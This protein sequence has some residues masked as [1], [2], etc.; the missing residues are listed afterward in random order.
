MAELQHDM[1]SQVSL[2]VDAAVKSFKTLTSAVKA[3]TTEWQANAAEAKRNGESQKA[4]QIK[5]DGLSKSVELQKAKL[6]D[7]KKQQSEVDTSTE[8]GTKRYYDLTSQITKTNSQITK[9]SEQLDKAKSG[10][11]YYTTGLADLQKGYKEATQL[12]QSYIAR[13]D[14]EG[15]TDEANK[16]KL[17]SYRN[18][19]EHFTKQL[20][21]QQTEL[22]KVATASGKD[23]DAYR[24]Q[25]IRVNKT[26]T[27]LANAKKQLNDFSSSL[28]RPKPM[29]FFDK[30]KAQLHG[31]A[32]AAKKTK[33]SISDIVKGSAVGAGLVSAVGGLGTSLIDAAKQ[34]FNLAKAGKEISENWEHIGVSAKGVKELTGQIGEIRGVSN[35]SGAAITKLQT[36]IYGLTSGNIKETKALTNELYAFG[37][38]GGASEDQIVQIGSKLTRIFS[39][40]KVNLSSF[41]KTFATMPGLKTAIQKAS[42]M[43]KSAFNDALANGKI[44]GAQM[45]KYMLEAADGSGKAWEKF[46]E[47]TEGKIAKTKGTWTNFTAA[48]MKPLANTA[49]DGLSKGLDKIIGKNGQLN[50]TGKHIQTIAGALATKVGKGIAEAIEFIVKNKD[51]I[52]NVG[53]TLLAYFAVQKIAGIISS[54]HSLGKAISTAFVI[55][56]EAGKISGLTK[57]GNLFKIIGSKALDLAKILGGKLLSAVKLAG[58]GLSAIGSAAKLVGS[59]LLDLT[60]IIG[61]KTLLAY[62]AVQKIA[63]IISSVHSLGKAISTAFVIR[64]EAGK[65]SGLTK[66]GNLFK[67]IGSKALDLAKILGGKLLSAVKLAGKGLSAIGSAAKLV[68]SKLLDL[69]KIIG[70]KLFDFTKL[71]GSKLL[72]LAKILGGKLLSAL[73]LVGKSLLTLGK[74]M[75]TNPIGLTITAITALVAGFIL[76]YK[77]CKPFRDFINNI[78]KEIKKAFAAVP[79]II[80]NVIKWFTKLYSGVKS[81]FNKINKNIKNTWKAITK[82]FNSFKKSFKED[83]DKLWNSIHDFFKKVWDKVLD[84]FKK[85]GKNIKGNFKSFGDD[86]KK[87]WTN[88]WSGVKSIFNKAW[89]GIKKLG[90]NAMNG[91]I[92][93]VNGG[94][95]AV[96]SVIHAFGGKKQTIS[97]LGHV[98]FA[99]GTDSLLKS[100]SNP[101]T[102]PVIA[103]LNDGND[104]PATGNKEMLIDDAGNAGIVQGRNTEMLLTPGMHVINAHETAMFTN[105]LSAF[106]HKRFAQGT[107]SIFGKIGNAVSGAVNGIGNWISKTASNLKK[108]F[109][110]AV[111]IVSHPIK[112]VEGLF[113]W[114]NPGNIAGAMQELAHGAFN[115]AQS[116]VKNWWS[117]LWQ[118][119]GGSL[120]G[121]SSALLKAVEKY[122]SGHNYV[123]GTQGPTTF[124]CSG[125]VWYALKKGF[126]IDYPRFSGSQYDMTEHISKSQAHSGDLVFW[127]KGGSEHVGV[128]AG[129]NRYYSAQSPSQ[130]IH[131]NTLD[132]V[133]GKGAPKF[134]RVQ[135]LKQETD[136]K[137]TTGLQQF[138]K[139]QVG[140]GF[141]SF[142]SKLGSLFGAGAMG[143]KPSGSHKNWL[144]EAGFK[145]SD[146]GYI[147]YIVDHES[148][149][150]PKATNPESGA[151]GLPQS[152][153][154]SKMASAGSDWR[155]NPITQLRWMKGYVNSVYGG[156]RNAY[157]FWLQ[158]HA[159]ANGGL[160]SQSGLYALAEMNK[161]EMIIPLDT[162][163]KSRASQLLDETTRIVRGSDNTIAAENTTNLLNTIINL[164]QT[165]ADKDKYKPIIELLQLLTQNPIKVDTQ[166]K[167]DGKTLAKQL[168]KYQIRRQIGGKAGYAF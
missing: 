128:Y 164:L 141:F 123:W 12:S 39:A 21:I 4:Q 24:E 49:L 109:D 54:V 168:E 78:G 7:L 63:G 47:T 100:L 6:A 72:D 133:V 106:E 28:E 117:A 46:G 135:G 88:L 77:N 41:N 64:D 134:G 40:S 56:D 95:K 80:R 36:S 71:L 50:S 152:L 113:K 105:F 3:N 97:L 32:D 129:G 86:F 167:L 150:D 18:S 119:A 115:K 35:A 55:R 84:I 70:G 153:P 111:K 90:Q 127:G 15:K 112:Y 8:N 139:N 143:G 108:Y 96:N 165:I 43:T 157:N 107:D 146:F 158:H 10:M 14:A 161:P 131:M 31:T 68:G 20:Q 138:I 142:I 44:S 156:A 136:T 120:D 91:L 42:G 149:W 9:Q 2:D 51:A 33:T 76:L 17:D 75:L 65:I 27:S 1:A 58:K 23:S 74:F 155:T 61:G 145:P 144:A 104:S 16:A 5:I 13:L 19:V 38:A 66:F 140:N 116:S 159:Y 147:T 26:A 59:K 110:L 34:G 73:Q 85:W 102:K 62:F 125:L 52:A 30:I 124:D 118:M 148:N 60:K 101:I 162:S 166:V 93:I 103:T 121:T 45:K 126:G 154:G 163:K 25:E 99:T 69:T 57:F 94:I 98:K 132:S 160:V 29:G 48:V 92:D 122:G 82:S 53:K 22:S 67:I 37:K 79:G 137:A 151:Y 114:T 89:N 81:T 130:G 87:T 11:S 83:W